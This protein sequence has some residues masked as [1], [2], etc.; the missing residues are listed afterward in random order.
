[1]QSYFVRIGALAEI[2]SAWGPNGVERDS[3]VILRTAAGLQLGLV[4]GP[5]REFSSDEAS[6]AEAS[7]AEASSA[8]ASSA[9]AT[10]T[11]ILR[12]TTDQDELLI[13][14]L[15]RHKRTA[16]ER[17]RE[18]LTSSGSKSTLLDIDQML[19]GG[20]LVMHFLGEVDQVAE[21]ITKQIAEEYESVIRTRH[22]AKLLRDGCGPDCGTGAGCSTGSCSGCNAAACTD[23]IGATRNQ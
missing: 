10:G 8:E 14:R 23:R 19:D 5:S 13:G 2:Q 9:E 20:T 22:F 3:R 6:S 15:S 1:M 12:S 11:R 16:V 4:L 7:S 21:S 18:A 17:C